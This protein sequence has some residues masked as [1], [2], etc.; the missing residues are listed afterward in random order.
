MNLTKEELEVA[1]D[2]EK[3][4][5]NKIDIKEKLFLHSSLNDLDKVDFNKNKNQL[6]FGFVNECEG[7]CGT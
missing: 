7:Y 1:V 5:N 2:F 6:E 4:V 3:K